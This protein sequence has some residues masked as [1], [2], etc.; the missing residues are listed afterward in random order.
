MGCDCNKVRSEALRGLA[1]AHRSGALGL[2][3]SGRGGRGGQLGDLEAGALVYSSAEVNAERSQFDG[4]LNAWLTEY[5][6]AAGK[7]PRALVQQ[8]DDFV[9]RWRDLNSST[10]DAWFRFEKTR[11][12]ETIAMEAEWNH[13][14]A[15]VAQAGSAAGAGAVGLTIQ[16]STVTVDGQEVEADKVPP[17]T[18]TIDKVEQIAKWGAIIIGG[19]AAI[20][21]A[22]DLGVFAKVR[23]LAG[24]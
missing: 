3:A 7:L 20:K 2:F 9:Q 19:A 5:A 1:R 4:R 17:G 22:T 12:E 8:V 24:A 23:K 21:V 6:A 13:L 16:P 11:A 18:S 14:R 15:Q 10:Y